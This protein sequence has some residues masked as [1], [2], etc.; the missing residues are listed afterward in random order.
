LYKEFLVDRGATH[1]LMSTVE[2][3][4]SKI[5]LATA[6]ELGLGVIVPVGMRNITGTYFSA[7]C[8]EIPPAYATADSKSRARA[9]EFVNRFRD[10]PMPA[11]TVPTEMV[12]YNKYAPLP[13]Y[14]PQLWQRV[15]RF[16]AIA[17]ERPDI[18]DY[19]YLRISLMLNAPLLRK[20][21]RGLRARRNLAQCD[22][23]DIETLPK[24]FIYYPLHYTPESSI[25]TPA[26]Y[27][28][29]QLRVIDAL[30]FAMPSDCTLVV[31]EHPACLGLRPV[32][33]MRQV[34]SLPGVTV[35]KTSVPSIEVIK[36][37]ILTAT[38]TGTAA[39]EAFL[40]GRPAITLGQH[41]PAWAIG[42]VSAMAGLGSDIRNAINAPPP[43]DFV[44]E[45]VSKLMSV[46][47]PFFFDTPGL[48]G[49]PVL[50]V[51]NIQQFLSAL[52][53]H[54]ER[55]AICTIQ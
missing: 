48:P 50:R 18:F 42:R 36:R 15:K 27:F 38:V 37:A 30:R 10:S 55:E 31:K 54:L 21:I 43:D 7:G 11:Y 22:I 25:N 1:I 24:R 44:I 51:P 14:R 46:R 32:K 12:S 9:R 35:V 40:L 26:P 52:L 23:A 16:V 45:Q 49:E 28:V 20:T 29:D 5:A 13:M 39:F 19:E 17:L 8:Y 2:T 53:D 41:L 4:D 3:P 33:F 6:Q 34:R 47:Y